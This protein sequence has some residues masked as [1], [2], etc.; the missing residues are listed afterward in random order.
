MLRKDRPR[1]GITR[2]K[3]IFPPYPT[4]RLYPAACRHE[5]LSQ[6]DV[7]LVFKPIAAVAY[8]FAALSGGD[9]KGEF[10]SGLFQSL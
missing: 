1:G 8:A 9:A 6:S 2:F 5:D 3:G 10:L 7:M 4:S